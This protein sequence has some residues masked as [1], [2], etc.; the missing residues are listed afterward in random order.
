[1]DAGDRGQKKGLHRFKKTWVRKNREDGIE[2]IEAEHKKTKRD[3]KKLIK[4]FKRRQWQKL[5][6]KLEN[7][8]KGTILSP[9]D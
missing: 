9:V 5:C 4:D 7:W 2:V 8:E 6:D 3:L 1:M